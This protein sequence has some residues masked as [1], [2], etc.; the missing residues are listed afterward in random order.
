MSHISLNELKQIIEEELINPNIKKEIEKLINSRNNWKNISNIC[1]TSG[2]ILLVGS[3]IMTFSSSI[4]KNNISLAFI[5]GSLNVTSIS[6]LKFSSY[7]AGESI[8]RNKLLN[9]LLVRCNVS[10][11]PQPINNNEINYGTIK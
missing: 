1:E 3:T 8:E 4:Y 6:L 11:L 5:A 2:Q 10:P 9:D 7:A